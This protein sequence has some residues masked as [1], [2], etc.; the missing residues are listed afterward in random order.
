MRWQKKQKRVEGMESQGYV[1]GN[2]GC[3]GDECVMVDGGRSGSNGG[4]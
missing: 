1:M 2:G 4:D 3:D